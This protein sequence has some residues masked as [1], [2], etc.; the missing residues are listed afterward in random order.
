LGDYSYRSTATCWLNKIKPIDSITK[1][2][3][4]NEDRQTSKGLD[5]Y[6]NNFGLTKQYYSYDYQNVHILTMMM[7]SSYSTGDDQYDFVVNDLQTASLN[8]DIDWIIVNIH[9]WIYR[10]SNYNPHNDDLAEVYHPVFDQYDVDLVLSGHDHKY[11]RTYPI[12]FN[13]SNSINP[14][15]TDNNPNDYISPQGQVYAVV[16]TGGVNLGTIV[17]SS[18][19]V[20]SKQDDYFGQLD[21]RFTDDSS[22]LEG[23]FYR[24]GD[25]A[26]LDSFRIT[27]TGAGGS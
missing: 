10:S 24:N 20:A 15:V 23:R 27:K 16:G 8:P 25:N 11:H 2:N 3:I 26:I 9:D 14:I 18:P 7:E 13:P 4:G 19:F 1:I 12:K 6:M 17:G 5:Q 22:K 21:I